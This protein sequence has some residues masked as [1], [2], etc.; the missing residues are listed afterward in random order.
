VGLAAIAV[1]LGCGNV[2]SVLLP[3]RTAQMR[4]GSSS[5]GS[6]E[7]GCLRLLM[8]TLSISVTLIILSPV[9]VGIAVPVIVNHL[10]LL[11]ITLP[12]ALVYGLAIYQ[13][14]SWFIS[15]RLLRRMPEILAVTTRE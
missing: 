8:G 7:S 9:S 6:P 11:T 3:F 14:A 10:S 4:M 1:M 2:V 12:L 5:S 13:G 15:P